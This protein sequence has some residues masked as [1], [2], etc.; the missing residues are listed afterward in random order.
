MFLGQ[1]HQGKYA[2]ACILL[3]SEEQTSMKFETK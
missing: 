3:D 2:Q 1:G